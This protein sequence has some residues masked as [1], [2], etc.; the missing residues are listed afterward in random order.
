VAGSFSCSALKRAYRDRLRQGAGRPVA[1]VFLRGSHAVLAERMARRTGHFMPAS[2]LASQ[3]ATLEDPSAEPG[4]VT[5]DID[6]PQPAIVADAAA[7]LRAFR[8]CHP[9]SEK[10]TLR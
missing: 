3:L 8:N 2:L 7:G 5:V 4:V 9:T 1:F 10:E 6:R